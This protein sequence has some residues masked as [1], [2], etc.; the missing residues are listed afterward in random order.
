MDKLTDKNDAAADN[1]TS[2]EET[3]LARPDL[4]SV[5]KL[6][7]DPKLWCISI[8][9][10]AMGLNSAYSDGIFNQRI[11]EEVG[12]SWI[13][14]F[15]TISSASGA[16]LS[17]VLPALITIVGPLPVLALASASFLTMPFFLG[18][19]PILHGHWLI[20][21]PLL[22]APA[23]VVAESTTKGFFTDFFPGAL[24]EPAMANLTLFR[25]LPVAITFFLLHF[26]PVPALF[27]S[28]VV[29]SLCIGPLYFLAVR[30]AQAPAKATD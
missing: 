19:F 5:L 22:G 29:L 20:V 16:L 3:E 7:R 15:A 27:A 10:F 11:A 12:D 6:W 30:L 1:P 17:K 2:S 25:F 14:I 13:F 8:P 4:F 23:R 26:I 9:L 28:I 18:L 24:G 21:L